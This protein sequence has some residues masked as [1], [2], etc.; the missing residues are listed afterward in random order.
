V[1]SWDEAIE[2]TVRAD[3]QVETRLIIGSFRSE[4]L[5]PDPTSFDFCVSAPPALLFCALVLLGVVLGLL[6]RWVVI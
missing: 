6:V 5:V 2:V 4:R 1:Q 3:G